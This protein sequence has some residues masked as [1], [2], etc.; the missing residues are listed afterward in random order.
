MIIHSFG[1]E[2]AKDEKTTVATR[3]I[4]PDGARYSISGSADFEGR[5]LINIRGRASLRYPKRSYT[6]RPI[7][8]QDEFLKISPLGLPADSD[9]VLYAPYPD[10]T[11]IRDVLAYELSNKMGKYASHTRYVE[12]FVQE[13]AEHLNKM[14]YMGVYVLE[15]KIRRAKDRVNIEKLGPD[16]NAEPKISGGYIFKKDHEV[17]GDE[18]AQP[19]LGG[20]PGNQG[21]SSSSRVGFPTGPGSF[22]GDPAGFQPPYNG[23]VRESSSSS[24]T[25]RTSS[26]SIVT[27]RVGMIPEE[28]DELLPFRFNS[29]R[30]LPSS[31]ERF[32]SK[33]RTNEFYYAYPE[34][35]EIT[36][37]QRAWLINHINKVESVLYGKN[38][39]N[40]TNGYRAYI[41]P[42]T[43]IDHHIIVEF[44]KN[45]DGFRFSTFFHKDRGGKIK[46]GPIWDWNLSFGNANGKQGWMPEYWLWPQL[47][48]KE[49]SWFRRLFEDPDFA[50][51]YVDRWAQLRTNVLATTNIIADINARAALLQEAQVRNYERWPVLGRQVWPQYFVGNSY[52]EEVDFMKDWITK[53][54]AWIDAQFVASPE[55]KENAGQ[56]SLNMPNA[57]IVYTLDGSDPRL[58]GGTLSTKAVKYSGPFASHAKDVLFARAMKEKR[59]SAP[60]IRNL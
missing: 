16:D 14:S 6:I 55:L 24:S 5:A 19:N 22:P 4:R 13:G 49:Y 1:Q 8:E 27:N 7:D 12:L 30:S 58:P 53:R 41:D 26:S 48:D 20:F 38:F 50:Q 17:D 57:E 47:N 39:L 45:V 33:P 10:K 29:S 15:E 34:P 21:N 46:M 9:W 28:T 2:I 40:P 37:A 51:Q 3:L 44:S 56:I 59:W 54:L 43:F 42:A 52:A 36:A 31:H 35:D 32:V 23:P 18:G 60:T 25:R 11:F